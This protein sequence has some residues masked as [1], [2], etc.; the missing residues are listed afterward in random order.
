MLFCFIDIDTNVFFHTHFVF[1]WPYSPIDRWIDKKK[2][3]LICHIVK[4]GP[5]K[6]HTQDMKTA[7][8]AIA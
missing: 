6:T 3:G 4:E 7:A 8:H 2:R 5:E 1:S